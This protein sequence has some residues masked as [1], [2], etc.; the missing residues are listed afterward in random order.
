MNEFTSSGISGMHFG[1]MKACAISTFLTEFESSI[2]H[3]PFANRYSP[4]QWQQ[5]VIV[6]IQKKAHVDLVSKLRTLVLTEADL[7]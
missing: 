1:H 4:S 5:G 7:N 2:S 3:I 6:T